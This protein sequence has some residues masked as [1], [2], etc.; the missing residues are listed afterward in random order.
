MKLIADSLNG[1]NKVDKS[2]TRLIKKKREDPNIWNQISKRRSDKRHH[3]NTKDYN[4]TNHYL[5][6]IGQYGRKMEIFLETYNFQEWIKKKQYSNSP[7]TTNKIKIV[8]K[9]LPTNKSHGLGDFTGKF[10]QT[11]TEELI[12]ILFKQFQNNSRRG[13]TFKLFFHKVSIILIP[14]PYKEIKKKEN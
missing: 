7:I 5:L 10:Y 2:L 8:I 3:R 11:F 14:K 4:T 9:K 1:I 13:K 12:R 6:K